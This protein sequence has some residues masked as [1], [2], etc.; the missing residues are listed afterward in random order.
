MTA[1]EEYFP[2]VT[3]AYTVM[4]Y[5]AWSLLFLI[6]VWQLFKVFGGPISESEHPLQL[7]ARSSIF[8][9]LIGYAKPIFM[10]ALE[11]ARAPYT[12]FSDVQ[13]GADAF[14]FAGIENVLSNGIV[15]LVSAVTIVGT[16]LMLIFMIAMRRYEKCR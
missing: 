12:A 5:M 14:T 8:A 16:I 15:T 7:L 3:Q 6:T 4:Q 9:V 11:I 2:F 10:I 13:M 1:M